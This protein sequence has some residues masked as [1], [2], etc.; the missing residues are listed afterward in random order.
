MTTQRYFE[1][2]HKEIMEL[3]KYQYGTRDKIIFDEKPYLIESMK[4]DAALLNNIDSAFHEALD[5]KVRHTD[6]AWLIAQWQSFNNKLKQELK[7]NEELNTGY[8]RE[9]YFNSDGLTISEDDERFNRLVSSHKNKLNHYNPNIT[10]DIQA[11]NQLLTEGIITSQKTGN[12]D[13]GQEYHNY[14]TVMLENSDKLVN[15]GAKVYVFDGT[16][17][18]SPEYKLD[19]VKMIDCSEFK[20]DLSRLTINIVDVNTSK[21][22]MSRSDEKTLNLTKMLIEYIKT[23]PQNND[24]VFTYKTIAKRFEN[25]FGHVNYFGNIKGTNQYRD[26]RNIVQIGLNRMPDLIYMLYANTI[27]FFNDKDKSIINRIYDRETIDKLMY[28]QILSDIEQNIFR[29]KIRNIDNEDSI[30]YTLFFDIKQYQQLIEMIKTRYGS[31]GANINVI[32]T[33][34]EILLQKIKDRD[35]KEQTYSQVIVDWIYNHKG[36]EFKIAN[37]LRDIGL[38]PKQFDRVKTKN[39]SLAELFRNMKTSKKGYYKIPE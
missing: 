13:N 32:D 18:I 7:N 33:P 2:T 38:K 22:R 30:V 10:K 39:K 12:R 23:L 1:K 16:A 5:N 17:D 6:K 3:T 26:A 8:K 15:I 4:I 34:S 11:I 29:S 21:N 27:R 9:V 37:M 31:I 28:K 14:F 35:T 20:R 24:V 25:H 19:F 36:T